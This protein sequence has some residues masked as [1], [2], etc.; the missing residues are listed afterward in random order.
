MTM[1]AWVWKI[2]TSSSRWPASSMNHLVTA[3]WRWGHISYWWERGVRVCS[4]SL[5]GS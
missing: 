1:T 3:A 4:R 2:L 5:E